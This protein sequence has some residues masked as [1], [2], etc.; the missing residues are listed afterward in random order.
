MFSNKVVLLRRLHK[1]P[2]FVNVYLHTGFDQS[3][4]YMCDNKNA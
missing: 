3:D 4:R 1:C 2:I